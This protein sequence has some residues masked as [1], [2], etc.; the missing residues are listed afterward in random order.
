[1]LIFMSLMNTVLNVQDIYQS[2]T[3][4]QLETVIFF[5]K[6]WRK[7]DYNVFP[8]GKSSGSPSDEK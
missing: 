3:H 4:A 8:L 5:D 7:K 2:N 1:M 6:N